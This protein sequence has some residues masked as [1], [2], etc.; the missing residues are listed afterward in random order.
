MNNTANTPTLAIYWLLVGVPL[1]WGV[2]HTLLAAGKLF[3]L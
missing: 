2:Y 1:A 3:G